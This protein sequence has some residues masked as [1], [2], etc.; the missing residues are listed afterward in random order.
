MIKNIT[1]EDLETSEDF[2]VAEKKKPSK[3]I[4]IESLKI[5]VRELS[6]EDIK[7]RNLPNQTSGLVIT[8]IEKIVH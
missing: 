2:K 3:E 4:Y 8:K 7:S 1:L 5:S 6:K